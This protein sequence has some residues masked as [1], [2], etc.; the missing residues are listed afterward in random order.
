MNPCPTCALLRRNWF[1]L[2]AAAGMNYLERK[3]SAFMSLFSL[4]FFCAFVVSIGIYYLI[5]KKYQWVA[6]LIYSAGF[7]YLSCNPATAVYLVISVIS[8]AL[9]AKMIH[10]CKANE[11]DKYARLALITGLVINLGILAAL[12][13]TNFLLSNLNS[14]SG[15]LK[16]MPAIPMTEW[17][18]PIGI[19]FYTMQIIAYLLDV[20]WGITEPQNNVAKA[21][22]FIGYWPQLTS[23]PI[24]RYNDMKEQLYSGHEFSWRNVTFGLQRMLWGLFKKLVLSERLAVMV[25]MVYSDTAYFNGIYIWAAAVM[26]MFQLYTD[27]SG[28]MDII[29]GASECYGIVLPENFRRPFFS[30]SVQEYWQRWHITLGTWLKDYVLYP[31]MRTRKWKKL[32][33][34]TGKKF[35][36]KA[37]KQIP[38]YLGML[39]VWL[40]IGLWHG[41]DWKY[42]IGMG[43]WFFGCI[44]LS[45]VLDPWFKK[46]K[47]ALHINADNGVW[48]LIQSLRV[49]L[50]VAIGNVFFR[51]DSLEAALHALMQGLILEGHDSYYYSKLWTLG[52]NESNRNVLLIGLLILLTVSLLQ[53]KGSVRE[54]IARQNIVI[55]WIIYFI[56]IFSVIIL[57]RYG[58]GFD[59]QA[60]IYQGF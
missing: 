59:A 7:F 36:G 27:F 60:F 34:K 3:R 47:D 15:V 22:L 31:L 35:R 40:L 26:F 23:G 29:I 56:L 33:Q 37:A 14:L 11:N 30:R 39:V 12:K 6:L 16:V 54:L 9:A 55:R 46:A 18:A 57:G 5:P 25:D 21:A 24:A 28:C 45:K 49:L 58:P 53:R 44:V 41:G 43:L 32:I 42:I 19:S 8:A 10:R 38:S 17:A 48:H 13:Y 4:L 51:L 52:L 20:Y 50:L 2:S 1:L